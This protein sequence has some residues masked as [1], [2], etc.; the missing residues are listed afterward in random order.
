MAASCVAKPGGVESEAWCGAGKHELVPDKGCEE[1]AHR[2][3][4]GMCS[5]NGKTCCRLAGREEWGV[6]QRVVSSSRSFV[7]TRDG[8]FVRMMVLLSLF[9]VSFVVLYPNPHVSFL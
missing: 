1:G 2:R 3:P 4:A 9:N 7:S 8:A 5:A 6:L